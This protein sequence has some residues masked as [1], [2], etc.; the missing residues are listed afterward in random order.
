MATRPATHAP[1]VKPFIG[2]FAERC[3]LA[4]LTLYAVFAPHSIAGAWIGLSFAILGWLI[5]T[6]ITRRTGIRHTPLDLPLC[7]FFAW[8]IASAALSAEPRISLAKLGSVSAFLIFYL[9]QALIT[10]RTAML[11]VTLMLASGCAGTLWSVGELIYGR[12]IIVEEI[13]SNS[14]LRAETR[15]HTGDCIW[16]VNKHRVSSVVE[17]DDAMRHAPTG[18][19]LS[20]SVI[21]HGE[22]VEWSGPVVTDEVK[23]AASPSGLKGMRSSHRFRASG[24]TRHYETFAETMQILA[25]LALGLMLAHLHRQGSRRSVVLFCAIAFALTS[26]GITLTAMRTSLI[27]FAIGAVVIVWRASVSARVRLFASLAIIL[28]LALGAFA[29]WQTR[30]SGALQLQ[31]DSTHLRVEVARVALARLKLHPFFGH[32]MDAFQRHWTE[33]GFPGTDMLH[34]HSTPLQI[35]FERGLPALFLWFWI[36]VAFWLILTRAEKSWRI[37]DDAFTHGLML[38]GIGSLA[39]FF[40][41]SLVNYNFGDAEVAIMLWWLMGVVVR[42]NA[43]ELTAQ[44][45]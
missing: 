44:A 24:W 40:A 31:D 42:I 22:H 35:A 25:Q 1:G 16:R 18:T 20:L 26:I 19:P 2:R 13:A 14:P 10:R 32:G 34:T 7:L 39:G 15:L 41:S 37:S 28:A 29:V 3:A 8:S 38:G 23:A 36:I 6:I 27:A 43:E 17:I 45:E 30:S 21:T 4:G 33:W 11:L 5:R 9:V 12:G